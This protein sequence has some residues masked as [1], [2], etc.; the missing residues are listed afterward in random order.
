MLA[1]SSATL[2]CGEVRRGQVVLCC[3]S[4]VGEV[5]SFMENEAGDIVV[6]LHMFTPCSDV[7]KAFHK[8]GP[9]A[10]R[11]ASD[12]IAKLTWAIHR[13]GVVRVILPHLPAALR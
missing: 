4:S 3:D 10:F 11:A 12:V 8:N 5:M 6:H 7:P 13:A 2:P 1:A 9:I